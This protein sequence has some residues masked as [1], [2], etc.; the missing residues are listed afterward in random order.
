MS[1]RPIT[2]KNRRSQTFY[3]HQGK[4]K[5]GR[6]NYFF[7]LK[8]SGPL[9]DTMPEGYEMY[10]N[11]NGQVF[12]CKKQP[13]LISDSEIRVVDEGMRKYSGIEYYRLDIKKNT[14]IVYLVDQD[15][16]T[17]GEL[18]PE[19]YILKYGGTEK[20]LD[21]I[22]E[23]SPMM[24]FVLT[25]DEKRRFVVERYCFLGSIDDWIN[26]GGPDKLENLTKRYL[27]HL[28]KE[29]FFELF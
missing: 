16:E 8:S 11:P 19:R 17:I 28:G 15:M 4:T 2:Y 25:D 6:P 21:S 29:S 22:L 5:I 23:Y 18:L 24:R 20:A 14:I 13:K 1:L 9:A 12:L 3:L 7:S 26:I 27:K 10:E